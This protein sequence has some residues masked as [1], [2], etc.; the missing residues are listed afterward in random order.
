MAVF[1]IYP[2]FLSLSHTWNCILKHSLWFIYP[3]PWQ[4]LDMMWRYVACWSVGVRRDQEMYFESLVL[5]SFKLYQE[6]KQPSAVLMSDY[7]YRGR[8]F[9]FK[10]PE[11]LNHMIW[12]PGYWRRLPTLD[13]HPQ[14]HLVLPANCVYPLQSQVGSFKGKAKQYKSDLLFSLSI[15]CSQVSIVL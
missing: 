3:A 8:K 4:S 5:R 11:C 7:S 14:G 15:S 13:S 9:V 6:A 12:Y 2:Q 10:Y 1:Q